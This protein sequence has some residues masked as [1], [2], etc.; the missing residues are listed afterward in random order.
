MIFKNILGAA[1]RK[2]G[3]GVQFSAI[4][5]R[6]VSYSL[7]AEQKEIQD[8]ARKFVR[9]EIIPVAGHYDKTGEFPWPVVKKAWELGLMNT[10]VPPEIGGLGLDVFTSCLIAEEI[11]YGCTGIMIPIVVSSVAQMPVVLGGNAEQKKNFLGRLTEQPLLA[12]FCC[13]EPI[14]GSDVSGIKTT[15][16]KKGDEYILNGQ[17]MWISNGSVANWYYVLAR[18]DPNPKTPA[19][20]AFTGFLV[21]ADTPGITPG[22]K[23]WN[24]GQRASDTR[25][26]TFEDVRIPKE[27]VLI[28]EGAGFKLTMATFDMSRPGLG[29]GAC[30]LARRCL[31]ESVKYS[32]DRKTFGVPI[33]DHQA[34]QF[35][36]A[37][38]AIT[39]ETTRAMYQ[40]SAWEFDTNV[41]SSYY[42]SIAK[43]FG[44]DMAMKAAL[45][46]VQ[47]FGGNGYNSEYPVEKLM[48]DAKIFQIYEGTS[49]IQRLII[50]RRLL[51]K[52]KAGELN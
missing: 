30:G 40:K 12:A 45:D 5:N 44:A 43:C 16:V 51:D 6:G 4:I 41:N 38:M 42:S 50:A 33:A 52:A 25:G 27:N 15:A 39:V 14:A 23:E 1:I 49:Q 20:K 21:N 19:S 36:L 9:E 32:M 18:T 24:M 8:V 3:L 31:D 26:V 2:Q 35:M 11:A 46:A 48:R 13:T 22:R 28:G 17:K 29:A 10:H 47:I 37:D 7:S 34:V